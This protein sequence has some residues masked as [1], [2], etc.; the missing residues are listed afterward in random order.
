VDIAEK[1]IH[2]EDLDLEG[3]ITIKWIFKNYDGSA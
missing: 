3:M 2:L 1:G